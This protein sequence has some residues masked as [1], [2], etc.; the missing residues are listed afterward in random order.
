MPLKL[1]KAVVDAD[2]RAK[3]FDALK[4][5]SIEG[6]KPINARQWGVLIE[7]AEGHQ[8]YARIGV[9]VAEERE[10]MTAAELM[11]SEVDKYEAAQEKKRVKAA[12]RAKKAAKD[13]AKR[14]A[15]AK[16]KEG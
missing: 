14:A 15:A 3:I 12:E 4:I 9:I 7:D 5:D 11:Q 8:R 16:E 2:I 6:F 13:A 10:D 1:S